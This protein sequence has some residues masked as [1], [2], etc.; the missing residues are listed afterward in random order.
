[1]PDNSG[2]NQGDSPSRPDL[3]D[4]ILAAYL[5]AIE[6]G[7]NPSRDELLARYPDLADELQE[8]FANRD[9]MNR[10]ARPL[11]EP[12]LAAPAGALVERIRYFGDYEVL[13]EIARGGMGVVFKARQ[14]KLNRVVAIKM[15]LSGQL[16][17]PDD[18]ERFHTEAEAAAKLD[19]P[20]IVPIYEVGE[21]EGQHYFSMGFVDGQSLSARVVAGPLPV[22]EAAEIVRTVADAV[23]YAHDNGVVHRDLKPGNVLLDRHGK[24][25]ITDFGLAK[26]T[27]SHAD[28]TGT[29]QILGT[30]GYMPP[31]QAAAH[32]GAVSP[33]SDIY[34]LGAIL[35][36]VLTGRPPFQAATPIETL[37]QVQKQEPVA[38]R[39]LNPAIPLD[40]D[41]IVLKCLE[42]SPARRYSS[43]QEVA[44]ELQRFLDGRPI[45]AR[46]IGRTARLWRW[47]R[48]DPAVASLAALLLV[49][50]MAVTAAS[51]VAYFG[52]LSHRHEIEEKNTEISQTLHRE[53]EAKDEATE[54]LYRSLVDQ[55]RANRMSR[56]IGQRFN[57]L[58]VL[59]EVSRM[60]RRMSR[61][62]DDFLELR[63]EA[64]ACLPLADVRIAKESNPFPIGS[65]VVE[66]GSTLER[67]ARVDRQGNVS[68]CRVV[69]DVELWNLTGP[70]PGEAWTKF[71]PDNQLLAVFGASNLKV[72]NLSGPEPVVSVDRPPEDFAFS[73]DSRQFATR[74]AAGVVTLFDLPSGRQLRQLQTK[75]GGGRFAYHPQGGQLALSCRAGVQIR[76]LET[77]DLIKELMR[78]GGS[79]FVAWRPDG[80]ILAAVG[81]DRVI[82]LWDVASGKPTTQLKGH[83]NDGI[84]FAFSHRSDLLA[85]TSW[86]GTLRLWDPETGDQLFQ[87]PL[88]MVW[89]LRFSPDD[90]R[91]AA[92][93]PE[94]EQVRI[95]EIAPVRNYYRTLVRDPVLGPGVY[96]EPTI[97]PDGRLLAV[98][99]WDG[100]GLWD[101]ISGRPVTFLPLGLTY[102]VRFE[103]S[104]ALL[105][106]GQTGVMRRS[107]EFDPQAPET[108]RIGPA[109]QLPLPGLSAN[110]GMSANGSVLAK[111]MYDG[112]MVWHTNLPA[113]PIVLS[114]HADVRYVSVSPDG[115]WVATGSHIGTKVKIWNAV[116]GKL[117]RELP[118]EGGSRVFFSGDGRWLV[119]TFAGNRLW[120]TA[121]W[122]EVRNI[123]GNRGG[124]GGVAFSRDGKLLAVEQYD[125][126]IRLLNPQTGREYARLEDPHQ[127]RAHRLIFAP[128]G[129]QLVAT[130][131]D[132][133]SIHAWDLRAIRTQL[134]EMGLDWDLLPYPPADPAIK[135][136]PLTM[137][138]EQR[139]SP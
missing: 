35:Y 9:R 27:E 121:S 58:E 91:L 71:S 67:Y 46:P 48:R 104:G 26:L 80:R 17:S 16:A 109:Q 108:V 81:G 55:A 13:E 122:Q 105:T 112:G 63:N 82:Q 15:I 102:A 38:P 129:A 92:A 32:V 87:T 98:G 28:L 114:P 30:P 94:A 39:Q 14:V 18:V 69:D 137:V 22:R 90:Q 65:F 93:L 62:E 77:G 2:P 44:D 126:I 37:L 119:T 56:R 36:C 97:S 86:D 20:G 47:C 110:I 128:D 127:D 78:T 83:T 88:L 25:R 53:S 96:Y 59:T 3:L 60:A 57:T 132:K 115:R 107:I 7:E 43:A 120:S 64:I 8:F 68:I 41:T 111:A 29:G 52:E 40:L 116:T 72:W 100:V 118:V 125:G 75:I 76:D 138:P 139:S 51:S 45:V 5:R 131:N 136:V 4:E 103:P 130:N 123:G 66:F 21:H 61:S 19:H 135:S 101:L 89:S 85:S 95:L 124:D 1:M 6:C 24:P 50:L 54:R 31:E 117:A 11:C 33:L 10:L 23:Q 34:S 12:T 99:M 70:G 134:A 84:F 113:P 106:S 73:P 49:A 133:K 79:G 42:K 74:N